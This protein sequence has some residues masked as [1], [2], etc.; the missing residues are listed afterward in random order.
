MPSLKIVSRCLVLAA[1][2]G[3]VLSSTVPAAA[4]S[5]PSTASWIDPEL[6]AAAKK[7]GSVIV[8]SSTNEQ[9]GL[10][11]FKLFEEATGIKVQYV[12]GS[13]SALMSRM[14]IEFRADQKS[15]DIVHTTT[16][17]KVPSQMMAQFDPSEAKNLN[18]NARDPGRRWYGVY[19]NYNSPAYNTTKVKASELPKI[20]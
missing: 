19:A 6:L 16:V 20:L 2:A 13:D 9:E 17:N 7:E 12:R 8:Y 5:V 3:L 18:A 14:A 10:P 4:Q 15:Y 1:S 11:L